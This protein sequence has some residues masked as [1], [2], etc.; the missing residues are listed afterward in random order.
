MKYLLGSG[1]YHPTGLDPFSLHWGN[2]V[3][4]FNPLPEKTVIISVGESGIPYLGTDASMR[5][6]PWVL[7]LRGNL[8]HVGDLISGAK[9]HSLCGWSSGFMT[10]AMLAY[11]AELDFL[12][13]EQDALGFG[14]IVEQAYADLDDGG[15]V[16][17]YKHTSAPWMQCSQ[18][19]V[20]V[21]HKFIPRLVK[22]YLDFGDDRL[23][24]LPERKFEM[25]EERCPTEVRRLSFGVDR[26][27][28]LPYDSRVWYGQKFTPE[29]MAELSRR[30]ML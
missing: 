7:P 19:L 27:R 10:L 4:R 3:S 20:L 24:N 13:F 18:S 5:L 26:E 23:A 8:G 14:P 6:H 1:Y 9:P 12:Y 25:I 21:K 29:E 22:L 30:N 17:G 2:N 15:I 11:N 16:F 28:P